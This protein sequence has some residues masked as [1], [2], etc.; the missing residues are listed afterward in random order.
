MDH[1]EINL[2]NQKEIELKQEHQ[3]GTQGNLVPEQG[4]LV[5]YGFRS[6]CSQVTAAL[7]QNFLLFSLGMVFAMPTVVVGVLDHKVATKQT[8]LEIPDLIL[9]DE[10]SSW[11]GSIL[12]LFHP[13]GAL[14]SGYVLEKVG[15]KKLMI[16]VCLPF[17][18][19]W[20]I[21]YFA[22]SV[23]M[24]ILG[25]ISMGIGVGCCEAPI[26]S[27]IGEISEPRMRGSLSLFAGAACNFGVMIIFLIH[28]LTDWRST[29]LICAIFPV[30]TMGMIAFIPESPTWLVSKGRLNEAEQ[31]L[32]WV[33]GWSKKKKVVVEFEQL[34]R[35]TSSATLYVQGRKKSSSQFVELCHNLTEPEI[36]RPTYMITS[37]F[38]ITII[39]S[40]QPMR[41]FLV[42]IFKTFG[43]PVNSDWVLVMTGVLSI[44]GS[45]VSS[46][47][48]NKF[49]KRGMCL[50][51]TAINTLF[52][53]ILS[54]CAMNLHWPG[55]FPLTILC[56]C[57]WVSGYGMSPLPWMLISEV[58]PV[59]VRSVATGITAASSSVVNF[60]A[61]KTYINLTSWFGLHG[62]LFIYTAVSFLGFFYIYFYVP[63]TEDRTLQ[64]IMDFFADN[65]SARD[66]KRTRKDNQQLATF[67]T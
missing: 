59:H 47:T 62:T 46:F 57:F 19:G 34:V 45:F 61:T 33:R 36:L 26:L 43:L 53:L 42:E 66:F 7:A 25:T 44:T 28:A 60:I 58:Y 35:D 9:S 64:E 56:I 23:S 8:I 20:I 15:R 48:V 5:Q 63:E 65:Q 49:G 11:L 55:W 41:P 17:I 4:I 30:V 52:T 6:A 2:Q 40:L 51:S 10:Q 18:A 16:L 31:S 22:Y 50:W 14:I 54:I 38:F 27:Y 1:A 39:A 67:S 12:Y 21:I 13:F 3:Q 24:I 32:R 29:V 37:L